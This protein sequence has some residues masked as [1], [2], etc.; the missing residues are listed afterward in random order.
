MIPKIIFFTWI[1]DKP[2]PSKYQKYIDSWR[3]VMPDYEIR[4]ITLE[5]CKRGKFVDK[6]IE[7]K[8]YALAGHYARCQEL[9]DHGGIY[10]D[11]DIEAVKP[12]DPLLNHHFVL[13]MESGNWVN[14]AVILSRKGHPFLLDCMRYMDRFSF[15]AEKIE[16]AT[17]PIMFTNLM[18][19]RGWRNSPGTFKDMTTILTPP[20]FYPYHWN[21]FY[22]PECITEKTF[23]VHHWANSWNNKVSIIIPCYKQAQFLPDA[24]ESALAQTYKEVEII[25]V[26]DGSPDNTS[27]VARK[28]KGVKLIEQPNKGLSAARNA[29]I[30]RASGGWILCLDAD[31]KIHPDFLTKTVGVNDIVCCYLETFGVNKQVWKPSHNSPKYED[32]LKRNHIF[33]ASLFKKDCWTLAGGYDEEQWVNG[34]QKA[35]GF[36]DMGF[37]LR[38][39]KAGF[40]VSV[41]PEVL[42][43]Y[44]K[45]A[46]G[47]MMTDA[48]KN[49]AKIIGY[50][51]NEHP[52]LRA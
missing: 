45:H 36:E 42:F 31:D 25:V 14:N 2:I 46:N 12:L 26:N 8:N 24:I 37:W 32:F 15:D 27:Q 4:Q 28:Y 48:M 49:R 16:L 40:N 50:M 52:L 33:C 9:Y 11:I 44:R 23:C 29:G 51:K 38:C 35:N 1:S 20:H 30:K 21:Q 3:R 17:G 18:K 41:V 10:F 34:K 7:I 22:T 19:K 5:N 39:T 13:G 47:S 43:Y 6:A